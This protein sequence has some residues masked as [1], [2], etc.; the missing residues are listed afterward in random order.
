MK[1]RTSTLAVA[2]LV[3]ASIMAIWPASAHAMAERSVSSREVASSLAAPRAFACVEGAVHVVSAG[4]TLSGIAARWGTTVSALKRANGLGGD[5]I[6]VGQ[7]LRISCQSPV[8][9][10]A[11][12]RPTA[13]SA[14]RSDADR[15]GAWQ[16]VQNGDTLASIAARCG[17]SLADLR[18]AN[19]LVGATIIVGQSLRIPASSSPRN[20][21][22]FASPA[23][24]G[25]VNYSLEPGIPGP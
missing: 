11:P 20:R 7:V 24:P 8:T 22:S 15:C 10:A 12:L 9:P 18:A 14:A 3:L 13:T 19:G 1:N 16:V 6:V 17:V 2:A 5:L 21:S 4:E 23:H 25:S